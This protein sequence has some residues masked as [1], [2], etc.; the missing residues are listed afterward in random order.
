M[1]I[2]DIINAPWGISQDK[3]TEITNVYLQHLSGDKIDF[4]AFTFDV[5]KEKPPYEIINNKAIIPVKGVLTPGS[6]FFTFYF[7]GTSMDSIKKN[8]QTAVEDGNEI[9]LHINSPGGT[10]E[11]SF[12]LADFIEEQSRKTSIIAFSDGMIA[13][14]AM[15]IASAANKIIITGKTNQVGSIGVIARRYDFSKYDEDMGVH[16]EEFVSGKYK[17]IASPDKKITDFDRTAIQEQVD[18]LFSLFA[19]DISRRLNISV[20]KIISMEAKIFIGEQAIEAGLVDGVSTIEGLLN[21]NQNSITNRGNMPITLDQIKSEAPELLDK[22]EKEAQAKGIEQGMKDGAKKEQERILAIQ[23]VA[24]PGMEDLTAKLI[25]EG[26]DPGKAAMM[27][28]QLE[29]QKGAKAL[30]QFQKEAPAAVATP[31]PAVN[32]ST[33]KPKTPKEE[34]EASAGLQEEF[35][36]FETYEAFL[37][38]QKHGQVAIF[39]QK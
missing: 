34:F 22:I 37:N 39:G 9:I 2:L 25:A 33:E 17:N 24:F 18:Y 31:E 11:G 6:S 15:L 29:K 23:S 10:V 21:D 4:K 27:F 1:K 30:E 12:E 13:S 32:T 28:N 16:I 36:T 26:S 35:G 5:D 8:I 20:D 38:A 7:G 14:A 3:L 19:Q